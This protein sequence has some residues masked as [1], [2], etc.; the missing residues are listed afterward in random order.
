MSHM[1]TNQQPGSMAPLKIQEEGVEIANDPHNTLNFVGAAVTAADSG[2][3]VATIT[4]TGG[5]LTIKDEGVT[6]PGGSKTALNFIGAGVTV[7]DGG[8]G[9]ATVNIPAAGGGGSG[10]YYSVADHG[11]VPVSGVP[12]DTTMGANRD[13]LISLLATVVAAGGG[14]I[15]FPPGRWPIKRVST[16][17]YCLK[18]QNATNV[19]FLGD[20]G[21]SI[22]CSAGDQGL[23][24]TNI[25][26]VLTC[27][28]I[29]FEG[30][31]FSQRDMTNC[32]EQNHMVQVGGSG[33]LAAANDDVQFLHCSF[34]E[35]A[36]GTPAGTKGGDAVRILGANA[37]TESNILFDGCTFHDCYRSGIGVQRNNQHI[38][39]VNC[40][41]RGTGDQDVDF[42]PSGLGQTGHFHIVGNHFEKT[43]LS[44]GGS[45]AVSL[46][47]TL[48]YPDLGSVCAYNTFVNATVICVDLQH[49]VIHGNHFYLDDPLVTD[50]T[51]VIEGVTKN[52]TVSSNFFARSDTCGDN[53][54]IAV[55][56]SGGNI[57]QFCA[58]RDNIFESY[59]PTATLIHLDSVLEAEITGNRI[60]WHGTSVTSALIHCQST[61]GKPSVTVDNNYGERDFLRGRLNLSTKTTNVS[62]IVRVR[63]GVTRP[64]TLAFV[65]NEAV[66]PTTGTLVL[67]G[68]NYVFSFKN[69]VTTVANFES[70]VTASTLLEIDTAGAAHAIVITVDEFTA[71]AMLT[72]A[73]APSR[74][75]NLEA[76]FGFDVGQIVVTNN[77][78]KGVVNLMRSQH[79]MTKYVDGLPLVANN[80]TDSAC[81]AISAGSGNLLTYW[82]T[83]SSGLRQDLEGTIVPEAAVTALQGS[84]YVYNNGDSSIVYVKGSGVSN[85]G[86]LTSSSQAIEV[87]SASGACARHIPRTN[88]V[89]VGTKAYTLAAG[90]SSGQG[91]VFEATQATP[92]DAPV[93]TLTITSPLGTEPATHVFHALAQMLTEL[94][95]GTGWHCIAKRRAGSKTLV[96]GT[97][98][99]TGYDMCSTYNL[100]ITGTVHSTSTKGIPDGLVEGEVIWVRNTV[101]AGGSDAGDIS[102]TFRKLDGTAATSLTFDSTGDYWSGRWDGSAWQEQINNGVVIA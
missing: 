74:L 25:V 99:A 101:N 86:W 97:T 23:G 44:R 62:T 49:T 82:C 75:L 26:Q 4:V 60:T 54:T 15:Y 8:G 67:T 43:L 84:T 13:A 33:G 72:Q 3:G 41:F 90:V 61:S 40:F 81:T 7:T 30:L 79:A 36:G 42:E 10:L 95:N 21:A 18:V 12:D 76:G 48:T 96:V 94:W 80:L 88:F 16:K 93:G 85:T 66:S 19:R 87:I 59:A 50:Q 6:V 56:P 17:V 73:S 2:G 77:R 11:L 53:E 47:G 9:V 35:G 89:I 32:S 22:L 20:R 69:G 46:F 5:S 38:N 100:S 65:D 52:V 78:I 58:I 37:L 51:I 57:P 70:L 63:A 64:V 24:D 83:G 31:T 92:S 1:P 98:V 14:T 45:C 27:N 55:V 68:D 34:I 39:I 29:T 28:G 71:A 91:K 102:G